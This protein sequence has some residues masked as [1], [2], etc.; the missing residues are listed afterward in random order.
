MAGCRRN[1][2]KRHEQN[3]FGSPFCSCPELPTR[4]KLVPIA[5]YS[6]ASLSL[7]QMPVFD[8]VVVREKA[9]AIV[10]ADKTKVEGTNR[11]AVLHWRCC[12]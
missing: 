11:A 2:Y 10:K 12:L 1:Y 4:H 6:T 8:A 5:S 3:R 9:D 7:T